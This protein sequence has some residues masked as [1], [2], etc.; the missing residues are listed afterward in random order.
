MVTVVEG[1]TLTD[2]GPEPVRLGVEGQRFVDAPD[3]PADVVFEDGYLFPAAVDMHVHF[4]EPGDEHK[5]TLAT[6]TRSAAFGGVALAAD[7]PNTDPETTTVDAYEAK[8]ARVEE[9]AH[10]DVG[11]WAGVTADGACFELG[12]RATGYKLYAGPTTGELLLEDPEA[13]DEAVQAVAGTDRPMAVHAEHPKVLERAA[14]RVEDPEDPRSHLQ[15]RPG[16]AEAQV[17]ERLAPLAERTGARLHGA[18]VSH[19]RSVDVLAEHGLTG[20]VTPHHVLLDED[21]VIEQGAYAKVNPPIRSPSTRK[22]L[23]SALAEG[24]LDA[25]AS[26]HA[27]HTR[28][29]KDAG[30]EAAPSGLPGVETLYPMMLARAFEGELEVSRVLEACCARPA[31]ILDV[32]A[33][34]LEPGCWA[35]LVHVPE[36]V[37]TVDGDRVHTKCGWTPFQGHPAVFPTDLMV[38]GEWALREGQLLAEPGDGRF[39]GGPAWA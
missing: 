4:R 9:T 16:E 18:H 6:G 32:P 30:F 12:D 39:V 36:Q 11:L 14:R 7:M 15:G 10:V 33:G 5:E 17:F 21:D 38:R 25:V 23:W 26:D 13:W 31:E 28:E 19:P 2:E 34:R 3:G 22:A 1:T 8:V 24:R 27:P 29:E 37:G 35:N 20:E